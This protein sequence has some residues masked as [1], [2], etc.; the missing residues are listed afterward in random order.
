MSKILYFDVETTGLSPAKDSI[1]QMA[2]I[3]E[4]DGVVVEEFD[5]RMKPINYAELPLDYVTPVGGITK[6]M[7]TN[8]QPQSQG[9]AQF[10]QILNKHVNKYDRSDKFFIAGYNCQAFDMLF[11]R[12]LFDR[13]GDTYFGTYFWSSSFDAMNIATFFMHAYRKNM[14]NFK[15]E[16][17]AKTLGLEVD[18]P[19]FH[20]ALSDIRITRQILMVV[21]MF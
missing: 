4:I 1:H 8:Y 14:P 2:G 5:I 20:D 6:A 9:F 18:G 16:T 17:V 10:K 19:G 3:V 13:N 15:L 12:T 11:L 21:D 7:M